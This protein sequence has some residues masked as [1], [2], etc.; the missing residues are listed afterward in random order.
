[1][2]KINTARTFIASSVTFGNYY[3]TNKPLRNKIQSGLLYFREK[4]KQR[5]IMLGII[6]HYTNIILT[7]S[8]CLHGVRFKIF[9]KEWLWDVKNFGGKAKN[10]R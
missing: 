7:G 5:G 1:M 9:P 6:V 3:M 2:S 10:L 4:Y 8:R